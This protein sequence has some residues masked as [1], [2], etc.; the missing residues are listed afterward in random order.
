MPTYELWT[1]R[2]ESWLPPLPLARHHERDRPD[3]SR[4]E[5]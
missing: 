3:G 4:S 1:I 2:R 5:D